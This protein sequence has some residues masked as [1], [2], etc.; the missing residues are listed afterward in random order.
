MPPETFELLQKI[1]NVTPDALME[2]T[3]D[4]DLKQELLETAKSSSFRYK[5][6]AVSLEEH[7]RNLVRVA[8]FFLPKNIKVDALTPEDWWTAHE[9]AKKEIAA[10]YWPGDKAPD[11][12]ELAVNNMS[13]ADAQ[14]L[15]LSLPIADRR[16]ALMESIARGELTAA[17]ALEFAA[18]AAALSESV[19]VDDILSAADIAEA[20]AQRVRRAEAA[21]LA[22]NDLTEA[23]AQMLEDDLTEEEMVAARAARAARLRAADLRVNKMSAA[24]AQIDGDVC[25]EETDAGHDVE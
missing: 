7:V 9:K 19:S 11:G 12:G 25:M 5:I 1:L 2:D 3:A 8:H 23:E 22:V 13:D 16:S 10:G 24:V 17:A 6:A 4:Y 21:D 15:D 18:Q 20:E 14:M